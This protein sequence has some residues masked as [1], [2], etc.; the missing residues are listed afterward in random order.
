MCKSLLCLCMWLFFTY[1]GLAQSKL[2]EQKVSLNKTETSIQEVLNHLTSNYQINFSYSKDLVSLQQKVTVI[3]VGLPLKKVLDN[4]FNGK[5]IQYTVIGNQIALQKTRQNQIASGRVLK[6]RVLVFGTDS[7]LASASIYRD[8]MYKGTVS[9]K[10]GY[11]DL[12]LSDSINVPVLVSAIGYSSTIISEYTPEQFIKVYLSPK[13]Y[14][15]DEVTVSVP[16]GMSR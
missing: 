6:G 11:F 16:D 13:A 10:D 8:G 3:V 2:L 7:A 14:E 9:N 5:G 1:S 15:L 12:R 4:I